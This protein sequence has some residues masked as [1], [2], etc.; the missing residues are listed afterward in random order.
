MRA[1]A[2]VVAPMS[3]SLAWLGALP[4]VTYA[5]ALAASGHL[6]WEH[7]AVATAATILAVA[8]D[9]TRQLFAHALPFLILFLLYDSMRYW[10]ASAASHGP[11]LA[12]SL[13]RVELA[14]FG[15]PYGGQRITPS[16]FFS[17]HHHPVVDVLCAIPYGAYLPVMVAQFIYLY[18]RDRAASRTFAYFALVTHVLGFA[19]YQLLPAAPPWYVREHGCGIDL[20]TANSPAALA[21]VDALFNTSYYHDLYRRGSVVF[22]ALPSLHVCYPLYGLFATY[23]RASPM[24][25]A[26]Q[27]GYAIVM[28]FAAIYLDHHWVLDVALGLVYALIGFAVV[29]ALLPAEE[30]EPMAR[31]TS[32]S[33]PDPVPTE[34]LVPRE[35]ASPSGSIRREHRSID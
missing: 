10:G 3:R 18:V 29:R 27:I 20:M 32:R 9:K 17:L 21:R 4:A 14:V 15:I 6:R 11:V 13:R 5:I 2:F 33:P 12:C 16:D 23:R 19:T 22:G 35:D 31:A 1:L 30:A 24:S 25:R 8:N 34:A 7:V 26:L 28:P